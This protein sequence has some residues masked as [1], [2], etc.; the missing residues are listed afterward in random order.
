MA[1]LHEKA[2][3]DATKRLYALGSSSRKRGEVEDLGDAGGTV[4]GIVGG[5][6]KKQSSKLE[7]D[8]KR[9]VMANA[10]ESAKKSKAIENE[11]D[12]FD[13]A[14][15]A[16]ERA[17]VQFIKDGGDPF[18]QAQRQMATNRAAED[19]PIAGKHTR[20]GFKK[21]ID[22]AEIQAEDFNTG[23][24]IIRGLGGTGEVY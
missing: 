9:A 17:D 5:L 7:N 8:K 2:L 6:A 14:N 19:A 1:Y 21:M 13:R 11:Y 18:A 12:Q 10:I 22:G 3:N 23:R 20:K 16:A 24:R 15:R 4:G